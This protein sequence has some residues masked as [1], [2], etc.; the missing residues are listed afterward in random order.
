[1]NLN[2]VRICVSPDRPKMQLA[3]GDYVSQAYREE[4][5]AW[6]LGFFGTVNLIPEGQAIMSEGGATMW[7]TPKTYATLKDML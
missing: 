4:I 7:V 5:D 2:G 1:M 3:P 6:L